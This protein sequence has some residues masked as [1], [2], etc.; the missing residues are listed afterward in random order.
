L[1]AQPAFFEC[2][3]D[4]E[5]RA[6]QVR[7]PPVNLTKEFVRSLTEYHKTTTTSRAKCPFTGSPDMVFRKHNEVSGQNPPGEL[8]MNA[9]KHRQFID[10]EG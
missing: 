8:S 3:P 7:N 6:H 10:S 4:E 9:Q 5:L 1:L 2:A